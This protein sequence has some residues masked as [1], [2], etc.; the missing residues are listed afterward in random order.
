[1]SVGDDSG[2]SC[3]LGTRRNGGGLGP[4]AG[5]DLLAVGGLNAG[6]FEAAVGADDGETVGF[7]RD[8]FAQLAGDALRVAWP[9]AA[10]RR[11]S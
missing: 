8:D 3:E 2:V 10:W 7:N 6:D 11:K 9:A 5:F 4:F 1:M